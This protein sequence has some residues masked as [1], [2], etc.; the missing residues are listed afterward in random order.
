MPCLFV[1]SNPFSV[2]MLLFRF[3]SGALPVCMEF[4]LFPVCKNVI[5][6]RRRERGPVFGTNFVG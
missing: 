1:F 6:N 2:F 3:F 4:C 5:H